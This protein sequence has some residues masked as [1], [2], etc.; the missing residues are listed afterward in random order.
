M[1]LV[2]NWQDMS[3]S[4][5]TD[6]SGVLIQ[7]CEYSCI[8]K[9]FLGKKE[10]PGILTAQSKVP[11]SL[12]SHPNFQKFTWR[13]WKNINHTFW[14]S[15]FS[16]LIFQPKWPPVRERWEVKGGWST[17]SQVIWQKS[18]SWLPLTQIVTFRKVVLI[19]REVS[20][21]VIMTTEAGAVGCQTPD[22][23]G[24]EEKKLRSQIQ[25]V[26]TKHIHWGPQA[27]LSLREITWSSRLHLSYR[28]GCNSSFC[29]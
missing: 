24:E 19:D 28:S 26:W 11:I 23:S 16:N 1:V 21:R 15:L 29:D 2:V 25:Q 12:N 18:I 7:L 5:T 14:P 27:V 22:T 10:T 9:N 17:W 20:S 13:R 8:T 4:P 3:S 6:P